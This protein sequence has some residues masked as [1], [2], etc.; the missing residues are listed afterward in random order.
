MSDHRPIHVVGL[1]GSPHHQGNT[2]T[3]MGWV[4]EGCLEA[5]AKT[6]WIHVVDYDIRY[7]RGCFTCLRTGE[8]PIRD[9]FLALRS[10]LLAA[11]GVVVGSPVYADAPPA[12]FKTFLDRLTLLNL[13]TNSFERQFSVGV[14]TS[15]IAPTMGV[16]NSLA[17]MFG[18]SSGAIGA[19]TSSVARGYQPLATVHDP[20]LPGKARA[21]GRRLVTDIRGPRRWRLPQREYLIYSLLTRTFIY[22]MVVGNPEQFAGVLRIWAEKGHAPGGGKN[23][24][25]S[26][27]T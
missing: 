21:L 13:Y 12:V 19:K 17:S 15:G 24:I 18:R 11:D 27:T 20:N 22:P 2:V 6:E 25:K 26:S 1:N 8:C 5:G 4:L 14:A 23:H 9:D 7:C 10:R 16:A 3:L